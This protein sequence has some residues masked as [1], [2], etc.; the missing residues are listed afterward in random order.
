MVPSRLKTE[1]FYIHDKNAFG[2]NFEVCPSVK[3]NTECCTF[4]V[5]TFSSFLNI[6][7]SISSTA[8]SSMWLKLVCATFL[9]VFFKSKREH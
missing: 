9:L 1:K 2:S 7:V 5:E 4:P 3:T 8:N 6:I